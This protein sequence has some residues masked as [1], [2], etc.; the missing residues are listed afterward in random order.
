[1]AGLVPAIHVL[2]TKKKS[3]MPGTGQGMTR[4]T[5]GQLPSFFLIFAAVAASLVWSSILPE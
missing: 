5:V 1:M 2:H 3:W 4:M